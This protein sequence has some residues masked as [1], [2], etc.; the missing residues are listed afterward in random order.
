MLSHFRGIFGGATLHAMG[1]THQTTTQTAIAASKARPSSGASPEVFIAANGCFWGTEHDFVKQFKGKG[2]LKSAVGYIG[3]NTADPSYRAVCSGNTGH[4]EAVRIEYDPSQVSYAELVEF[5]YAMHDPTTVN[6]QGNDRGT[7]YRSAIF[8]QT[9]EQLDIA[10]KVTAEVQELHFKDS[11]IV[12][13]LVG[14][15]DG[16]KWWDAEVR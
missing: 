11:K 8:A 14:P 15:E 3:G 9:P 10:K 16:F 2:L 4:A 12:T 5:N 6:R 7:Q 1:V 13:Q